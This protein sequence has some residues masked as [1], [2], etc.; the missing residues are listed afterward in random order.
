MERKGQ[1]AGHKIIPVQKGRV[2]KKSLGSLEEHNGKCTGSVPSGTGK[3][4]MSKSQ[5]DAN[6]KPFAFENKNLDHHSYGVY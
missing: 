1:M 3:K 5:P 6:F 2:L 4:K